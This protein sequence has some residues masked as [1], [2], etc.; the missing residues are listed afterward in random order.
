M[1]MKI[2]LLSLESG[3]LRSMKVASLPLES[4]E[5]SLIIPRVW[6]VHCRFPKYPVKKIASLSLESG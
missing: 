5:L 3:E 6:E 4:G 1:S 2:A